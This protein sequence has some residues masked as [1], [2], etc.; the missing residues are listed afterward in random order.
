MTSPIGLW[1]PILRPQVHHF[2]FLEPE[3]AIFGRR[4][5]LTLAT[6]FV[7]MV[8]LQLWLTVIMVMLMLVFAS[9]IEAENH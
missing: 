4:V 5:E 9:E 6:S 8:H 7:N 2:G 3:V 1:T